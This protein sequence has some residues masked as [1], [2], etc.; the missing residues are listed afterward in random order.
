[1]VNVWYEFPLCWSTDDMNCYSPLLQNPGSLAQAVVAYILA[2]EI[3]GSVPSML[4]KRA[5]VIP[6]HTT[7]PAVMSNNKS[8]KYEWVYMD[9]QS[10]NV[11]KW[12]Y[13][14]LVL[15]KCFNAADHFVRENHLNL[16]LPSRLIIPTSWFSKYFIL[17]MS[18]RALTH[19]WFMDQSLKSGGAGGRGDCVLLFF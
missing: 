16:P 8:L 10:V 7:Y 12:R 11:I 19:W 5:A 6:S 9:S 2:L 3:P 13:S 1:M 17:Q 18:A 4:A 14:R 15:L